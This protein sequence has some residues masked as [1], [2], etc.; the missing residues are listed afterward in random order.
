M[1]INK[2]LIEYDNLFGVASLEN[3]QEY[4]SAKIEQAYQE[5]DNYA[6]VT[7]LNEMIGLTRETGDK[8]KGI[9]AC[10]KAMLLMKKLCLEDT[11]DYGITLLNVA[12]AYRA[13]N[14]LD[15]SLDTFKEVENLFNS[16]LSPGDFNYASLY[17]N[18]S[19]LYE[20]KKEFQNARIMLERALSIVDLNERAFLEQATTRS[21]LAA[22]LLELS[23]ETMERSGI[24]DPM[25]QAYF[26]MAFDYI[27]QAINIYERDGGRDYHFSAA[28]C[29]MGDLQ[30]FA[31]D[32]VKA[33]EYYER[34]ILQH[35]TSVG[36]NAAY[37]II[38]S[39][40][41]RAKELLTGSSND[42]VS[43]EIAQENVSPENVLEEDI[44]S[45]VDA[46]TILGMDSA[47]SAATDI[48]A[49]SNIQEVPDTKLATQDDFAALN[50]VDEQSSF[51]EKFSK[52]PHIFN[53][54]MERCRAFFEEYGRPMIHEKFKDYED[55]IAAGLVGE[56][57]ECF[58][59]DDDISKDHDYCV[60]FCIWLNDSDYEKIGAKLN[61][62]YKLLIEKY[63]K[64][65]FDNHVAFEYENNSNVND[66]H[67][68]HSIREFYRDLLRTS[69][70]VV[71][72]LCNKD[73]DNLLTDME[74]FS[75]DEDD[76][77]T[78]TN[79][80]VFMDRFGAFSRARRNLLKYYPDKIWFAKLAKE[81]HTFS[82]NG[83]YNYGRMMARRDSVTAMICVANAMDSAMK[84][85][86]L[87]NKKYAPY[88][89]WRF[90]G[91]HKLNISITSMNILEEIATSKSQAK[92]W[93]SMYNPYEMNKSDKILCLFEE[94]AGVI[95]SIMRE[96]ELVEGTETFLDVYCGQ[97]LAKANQIETRVSEAKKDVTEEGKESIFTSEV[98]KEDIYRDALGKDSIVKNTENKNDLV[99]KIVKEEWQQFD[100]VE[101]EGGRAECQNNWNTFSIMRKS[102]YHAWPLELLSSYYK[103]LV[104]AR[105]S[106][107]NLIT[108][109][110]A[111]MM[112]STTPQKYAELADS[113]PVRDDY[114]KAIQ[115]QIIE[116][117]VEWMENFAK[118]YPKMAGNARS[119][120]TYEDNEFNTSYETY[121]RGELGTYSEDTIVLYGRFIVDLKQKGLNLAYIIMDNTAKLY[122]YS[123]VEEAESRL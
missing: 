25:C 81:L 15:E 55:R 105:E 66:R 83:Q 69:D 32:F 13:F 99:D 120:H 59:F 75:L 36:K 45:N 78:V 39:K 97:L 40:Y 60:G 33:C 29:V 102:Q 109:K 46:S 98:K 2:V 104:A 70:S 27:T 64:R 123:S 121:L 116:I 9:E 72:R 47:V 86:Y 57:S 18:W 22:T 34:A 28:L 21:N 4:L 26:D 23:K 41:N 119:I 117:Q 56:G 85:F 92:Y 51:T 52:N 87:L 31:G 20:E 71:E 63:G 68:V 11:V 89:K 53:N 7:L 107:W 62:E 122:G 95:L 96:M 114:R 113:L 61:E 93:K 19:L 12:N 82:Q 38:V 103:D 94:L 74:W 67:G 77:A 111:R 1:D 106:G 84:I 30:F 80:A 90:K 79:G 76:I 101:N 17:N 100:K 49:L 50:M 110:Y 35:E 16:K 37:D 65:Y 43:E 73:D 108:E 6:A 44:S 58:G 91:L 112:E 5:K 8:A 48:E 54:H 88:G 42:S 24:S 3:I 118:D 14:M 115:E 10:N